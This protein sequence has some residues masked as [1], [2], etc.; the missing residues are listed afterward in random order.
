VTSS[1]LRPF[2]GTSCD[3]YPIKLKTRVAFS[4]TFN[5]NV[6]SAVVVVPVVAA[7]GPL[8]IT[9]TPGIGD[10]SLLFTTVPVTLSVCP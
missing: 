9:D 6:P 8:T 5:S 10:P 2:K 7:D 4:V 3:L 1:L